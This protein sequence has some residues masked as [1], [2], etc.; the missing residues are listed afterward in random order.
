MHK[1]LIVLL[2]LGWLLSATA[3]AADVSTQ[4]LVYQITEPG[5]EPYVSRMLS[6]PAFLRL[7]QGRQDSGFI[8]LDRKARVIYS[9]NAEDRTILVID[10]PQQARKTLP[11]L[12]LS[13]ARKAQPGMPQVAGKTPE[14]WEFFVNDRL[15]R[16]AVVVPGLL[17][18]AHAA[19]AEY[20]DLLAYQQLLTQA[21]I[22]E[23]LQDPC[24]MAIHV[25]AP[26]AVLDKGLPLKEWHASGWRQ[27]LV[28]FRETFAVP[29]ESFELPPDY[30]RVPLGGI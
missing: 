27:E 5:S 23:E 3:A 24:D 26:L 9:V 25:Y 17:P 13:A 7:D 11:A 2:V 10:P 1:R 8:L 12:R 30:Q 28:D 20:L 21:A 14:H 16:S 19:Y 29:S 4:L 18:Q 6:T 22:P 15:C